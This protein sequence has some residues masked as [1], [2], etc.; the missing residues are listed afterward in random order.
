MSELSKKEKDQ[1][2]KRSEDAKK[3]LWPFFKYFVFTM[4]EHDKTVLYKPCPHKLYIRVMCRAA[5][6]FDVLLEEKSRQIFMSWFWVGVC[7]WDAMFFYNRLVQM[8]GKKEPDAQ[9]LLNRARHIYTAIKKLVEPE[10]GCKIIPDA[11]TVGQKYGTKTEL[12]FPEMNSLLEAIPEGPDQVRSNTLSRLFVDEMG[13]Q[14]QFKD[15]MAAAM[16]AIVGGGAFAGVGTPKGKNYPYFL[17]NGLDDITGKS[18]GRHLVDSRNIHEKLITPP[19]SLTEGAARQWIENELISMPDDEFNSIPFAE[20]VACIPG[21]EYR[22]TAEEK[23]ILT[24]HY[25]AD[26][27]KDPCTKEGAEWLKEAKRKFIGGQARW[28]QEYE[29]DYGAYLGRPVIKNWEHDKFVRPCEYDSD[30]KLHMSFDFGT[31]VNVTL[32][33]QYGPPKLDDGKTGEGM[34]L[35]ILKEIVLRMSHTPNQALLTAQAMENDFWRSRI[36]KNYK[37][38][39]DPNG[40]RNNE[41][42]SD[43]SLNSSIGILESYGIY[44]LNRKFG[45]PE[46]TQLMETVFYLE[47]PCGQPAILIDPSCEYLISCFA[48]GLHYPLE[49]KPG[50]H[51]YYEKDGEYEHG[52]DTARYLIANLFEAADLTGRKKEKALRATPI[53]NPVSG[54]KIG[55]RRRGRGGPNLSRGEHR[56]HSA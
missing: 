13:E 20:L 39:C 51:G 1:W 26:P 9:K 21:I 34:Q 28:N 12:K 17:V 14:R 32:F 6:E 36:N 10:M 52:G 55:Y 23:D 53:Y 49:P 43:R 33:A 16:P 29:I 25:T 50:R 54:R 24:I 38:Y 5:M 44:P 30:L 56:V 2:L 18:M 22:R 42:T 45:V 4:D 41:T 35:R 31:D 40:D 27:E 8:Q 46:S 19:P 15:A 48:G 3:H 7:L 11:Q 47:L 37:A